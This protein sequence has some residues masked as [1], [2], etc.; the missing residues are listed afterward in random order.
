MNINLI[1]HN[2]VGKIC[3]T[4]WK[5]FIVKGIPKERKLTLEKL[6]GKADINVR[7]SLLEL[8]WHLPVN[9]SNALLVKKYIIQNFDQNDIS[10]YGLTFA[11]LNN[12]SEN[13]YFTSIVVEKNSPPTLVK[14][15]K[16]RDTYNILYCENFNPNTQKYKVYAQD[17]DKIELSGLLM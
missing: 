6:L 15:F 7:H 16:V 12:S 13:S 14:D 5:S 17:V 8:N 1:N 11:I 2:R 3:I 4:P 10:T 9:D